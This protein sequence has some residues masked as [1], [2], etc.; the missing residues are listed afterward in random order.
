MPR[1]ASLEL[2]CMAIRI[3]N[4]SPLQWFLLFATFPTEIIMQLQRPFHGE[5]IRPVLCEQLCDESIN[6]L[7][8]ACWSEN[9]DHRPPF[10]SIRRQLRDMSPDRCGLWF[11]FYLDNNMRWENK[12]LTLSLI[13]IYRLLVVEEIA[14]SYLCQGF[15]FV[16]SLKKTM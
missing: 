7:L 10:V 14:W 1:V 6:S 15:I 13:W 8:K 3:L 2:H 16:I 9:P 4:H 11:F 5:P 12:L